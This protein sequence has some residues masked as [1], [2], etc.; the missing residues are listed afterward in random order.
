M[1]QVSRLYDMI[2]VHFSELIQDSGRVADYRYTRGYVFSDH[3]ASAYH[4]PGTNT[5]A[6]Q[7]RG[8][9]AYAGPIFNPCFKTYETRILAPGVLVIRK[10]DIGPDMYIVA[11]TNAIPQL[12]TG[13]N[14]YAITDN[15]IVFN[16]A[17][18][19]DIA[20]FSDD[21]TR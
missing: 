1:R 18:R 10:S 21:S 19:A 14:R 4:G 17:M 11:H 12:Y 5:N 20:I 15:D 16:E 13:F 3:G 6:G 9:T 8:P 7:D 2:L